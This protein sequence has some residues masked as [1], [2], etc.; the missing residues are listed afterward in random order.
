MIGWLSPTFNMSK[1]TD[2]KNRFSPPQAFGLEVAILTTA[3]M[4]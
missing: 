4:M 3:A 2:V 1:T